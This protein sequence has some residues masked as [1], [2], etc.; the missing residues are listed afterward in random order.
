MSRRRPAL[1]IALLLLG[2]PVPHP[3]RAGGK[4]SLAIVSTAVSDWDGSL[5]R[6]GGTDS[7]PV[8]QACMAD[9]QKKLEENLSEWFDVVPAPSF[10]KNPDFRALSTGKRLPRFQGPDYDGVP[11]PSFTTLPVKVAECRIETAQAKALAKTLGVERV[12]L[13][14]SDW[15]SAHAKLL[16]VTRARAKTRIAIYDA[17]GKELLNVRRDII[18]PRL[19]GTGG[20]V[21]LTCNTIEQW[22]DITAE[23]AALSLAEILGSPAEEKPK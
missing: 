10:V 20:H 11:L 16:K 2:L 9:L 12:A 17:D 21:A 8:I 23:G 19:L 22:I 13:F 4:P 15:S 14:Y 1:L 18:G 7:A 5:T 3:A 6:A